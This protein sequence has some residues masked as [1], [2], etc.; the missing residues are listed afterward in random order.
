M[1]SMADTLVGEAVD[2]AP[3]R[4]PGR[5]VLAGRR[6]RLEPLDAARH[7]EALA[8]AFEG[9]ESLW[10]YVPSGPFAARWE[11]LRWVR[12]FS[13]V[14]DRVPYAVV[15]GATDRAVG[16]F[17]LAA[18]RPDMRVVEV[19]H[20]AFGS[21]LRGTPLATE[22]QYLLARHVFEDLGYRR[23]EWK[24]NSLNAASRQAALRLG[25]RF[26]G[27]FRQHMIVKGHNRDTAWFSMLDS[28]WPAR[29]A[30]FEAWLAPENFDADGRQKTR[31]AR[32]DGV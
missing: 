5:E 22:A 7:G 4:L 9:D 32:P 2:T 17:A 12:E 15:D 28:E 30:A 19:A 23:Y 14:T 1:D 26:E 21:A 24:C 3:A 13:Q 18:I 16:Y 8:E 20:V 27:L 11:L 6:G 25:F 10:R 29:R 31:L